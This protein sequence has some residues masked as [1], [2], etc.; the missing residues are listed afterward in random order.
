MLDRRSFLE[1]GV[2]SLAGLA[3]GLAGTG[4]AG[5]RAMAMCITHSPSPDPLVTFALLTDVHYADQPT[6]GSRHYRDSIAKMRATADAVRAA[7]VRFAVELGDFIDTG[8]GEITDDVI[9]RDI[10]YLKA[11]ETEFARCG[12]E[13]HYVLGNHCVDVLTKE[14]FAANCAG[15]ATHYSFTHDGVHFVVLDAC[16]NTKGEPYGR[17]N[18]HWS[19]ANIPQHQIDWLEADLTKADEPTI[20]FTHQRLDPTDHHS[21]KNAKD[22]RKVMTASGRVA[23]VFQGHSHKNAAVDLDGIHYVVARAMVEGSGVKSN[24]FAV[25]RVFADGSLRIEGFEQQTDYDLD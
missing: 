5:T 10:K 21:V 6:R 16:Y 15:R 25:V 3:G 20:V 19:D 23:A 8:V 11:I 4:L 22:V 13:R 7:K 12:E 17:R 9:A 14:E 1:H 18:A 2:L 24:G